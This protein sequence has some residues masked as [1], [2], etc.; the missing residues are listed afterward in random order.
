MRHAVIA[1]LVG[2]VL[3]AG[4]SSGDPARGDPAGSV[5]LLT[6]DP[7]NGACSAGGNHPT[8]GRLVAEGKYGTTF[9]GMP[10]MWPFGYTG[11][12]VGAEVEVLDADGNVKAT[13]G[14][15][16]S[17]IAK[18]NSPK[19]LGAFPAS[20]DCGGSWDFNDCSVPVPSDFCDPN[21]RDASGQSTDREGSPGSLTAIRGCFGCL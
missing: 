19:D 10:V 4:C 20:V 3:I 21:Y 18:P 15:V 12:R 6:G 5:E 14:R 8:M 7:S 1:L 13:T 16:Y 17:I 11:R 9:D 2:C